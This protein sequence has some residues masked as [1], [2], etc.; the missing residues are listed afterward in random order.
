MLLPIHQ[1][2]GSVQLQKKHTTY[3]YPT[4]L[5]LYLVS[6]KSTVHQRS[7]DTLIFCMKGAYIGGEC[8]TICVEKICKR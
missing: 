2:P 4:L 5:A 6:T 7:Y 1:N 3:L 8:D